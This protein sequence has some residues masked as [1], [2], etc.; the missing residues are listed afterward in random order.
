VG[1]VLG[2]RFSDAPVTERTVPA[3]PAV[4]G[5]LHRQVEAA[6]VVAAEEVSLSLYRL[7]LTEG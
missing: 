3:A 1:V 6:V 2:F 5:S 4:P 7:L